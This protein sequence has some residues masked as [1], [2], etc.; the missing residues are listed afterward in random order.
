MVGDEDPSAALWSTL[1]D[2][3]LATGLS[4]SARAALHAAVEGGVAGNLAQI[5]LPRPAR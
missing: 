5:E 2:E 1:N 3:S 4:A